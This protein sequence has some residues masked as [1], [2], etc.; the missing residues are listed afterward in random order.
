MIVRFSIENWMSFRDKA[1]FSMIATRERQH[2]ERVPRIKKYRTGILPITALYGGN[3]SGKSNLFEALRFAQELIVDGKRPGERIPVKPF[4]LDEKSGKLPTAFCFELLVDEVVYEYSFVL[5]PNEIVEEKLVEITGSSEK[6][7]FHRLDGKSNLHDS[8]KKKSDLEVYFKGTRENE[9]FLTN[10]V[11]QKVE[12]FLPVWSWFRINLVL[13]A[14]DSQYARFERLGDEQDPLASSVNEVLSRLDIGLHRLEAVEIP[15]ETVPILETEKEKV[16]E[17]IKEKGTVPV[18]I[19]VSRNERYLLTNENGEIHARKLVAWHTGEEGHEKRFD[20]RDE[21]DGS[22]RMID[23]VPAL[24]ALC[25]EN[26]RKVFVVDEIDRSLHT[27]LT[28]SLLEMYLESCSPESRSQLLFTTH[29]A[30]LMDQDLLRR[31]EMWVAER[32]SS[33]ASR[34]FSFSEYKDVRYDKDI[35]KSYLQ[36]RLGGVPRILLCGGGRKSDKSSPGSPIRGENEER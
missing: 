29:D 16:L 2:N 11:F 12:A 24:P 36:G 1:E 20:L 3:A 15:L 17:K 33:G 7:L 27:L 25:A 8:L 9:L 6:T 34:I 14:P 23:L 26:S 21:S 32:D 22:I 28:R 10:T 5:T 18:R 4:R 19:K 13:I 30:L 35:M 31:D